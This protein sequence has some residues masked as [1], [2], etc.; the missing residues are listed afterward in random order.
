MDTIPFFMCLSISCRFNCIYFFI[1]DTAKLAAACLL[2]LQHV[3][4][5]HGAVQN[6]VSLWVLLVV[7]VLAVLVDGAVVLSASVE[8]VELTVV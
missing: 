7:G 3:A 4:L 8:E 1:S 5:L 6:G 2:N